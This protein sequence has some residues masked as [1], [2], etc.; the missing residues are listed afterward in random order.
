M[1]VGPFNASKMQISNGEFYEFVVGGGYRDPTL[2]SDDGWGWCCYRN[3][4]KPTFW[5]DDGPKGLNQYK[6]RSVFSEE[7][8][9]WDWPVIAN[10]HEA[11]AY[12]AWRTRKDDVHDAPYR[13]MTEAE[14]HQLR[15]DA[16]VDPVTTDSNPAN[17]NL[18]SGAERA[19]D[20]GPPSDS[21]F[22]DV[23]GNAWEW[24][25]D[26]QS[27]L[28]GF[29]LHKL[30]DDF[31]LPCFD[32]EHNLI[33]GG[34]FIS[35]GD[36]ASVHGRYQFRPHFFQHASFRLTQPL[37]SPW[38]RTSCMGAPGPYA[39]DK[40]PFRVADEHTKPPAYLLNAEGD[41]TPGDQTQADYEN[42]HWVERYLH[43]HFPGPAESS[44]T[45]EWVPAAALDYPARCGR[46]IIQS[47]I[48]VQAPRVSALDL[49]CAVG[50]AAFELANSQSGYAT[51]TGVDLSEAF[52]HAANQVK[53]GMEVPF[54]M[55]VEGDVR[56]LMTAKAP[57]YVALDRLQFMQG[58]ACCFSESWAQQ[59]YDAVLVGNLLDR[60]AKPK[61]LLQQMNQL[62]NPGGILMLTNP[63]S[64]KA[65]FTARSE[66]LGAQEGQ[67][68]Q[69]A[70][71]EV[72][73]EVGFKNISTHEMPLA[74]RH[75]SRFYELIGAQASIWQRK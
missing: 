14:H 62:V 33:M 41:D 53:S 63:Y 2:W 3:I 5:V 50:G 73:R 6:L 74:I 52:V 46:A 19:V 28:P 21:G 57:E 51:V 7:A 11:K 55:V 48:D 15:D 56:E 45:P 32:G 40:T 39:R 30:Y 49:G 10:Y 12:C 64:W 31:T 13:V 58:D 1:V 8:M 75:H 59:S 69:D 9:Q 44:T 54:Q 26:H 72:L 47:A 16:S 36:Q 22:H 67:S 66:W 25:E 71:A 42:D 60:L 65:Q 43:L 29:E 37:E 70:T 68:S 27:A 17:T 4:R 20:A 35:T 34:S 23:F 18:V 61:V 38:L 24:C